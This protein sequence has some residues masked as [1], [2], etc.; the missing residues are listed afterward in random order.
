[1]ANSSFSGSRVAASTV[2]EIL[3]EAAIAPAPE[4]ASSTWADFLRSRADALPVCGFLETVTLSGARLYAFAVIGHA[5]RR[6][7]VLGATVHPSASGVTRAAKNLVMGLEDADCRARFLV[8]GRDGKFPSL[9]DAVLAEVGIEVV[10]GGVRMP[11]MNSVMEG[12]CRS[13]GLSCWTVP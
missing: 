6:I 9:F 11:C 3:Q 2:G 13:V 12:G 8:R 1:M 10:P 4:R 5:G 7:R